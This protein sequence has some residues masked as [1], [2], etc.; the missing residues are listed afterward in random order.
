[1]TAGR[2][3]GQRFRGEE[4][5]F[6]KWSEQRKSTPQGHVGT[7]KRVAIFREPRL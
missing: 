7:P 2:A 1:M 6:R 4:G 5:E 3:K